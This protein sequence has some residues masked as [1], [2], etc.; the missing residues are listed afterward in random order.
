M[1]WTIIDAAMDEKVRARLLAGKTVY[2][3]G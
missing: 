3:K 1:A 2:G